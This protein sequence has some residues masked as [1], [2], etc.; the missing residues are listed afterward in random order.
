MKKVDEIYLLKQINEAKKE[1]SESD[2]LSDLEI[3]FKD[4]DFQFKNP[5]QLIES[6]LELYFFN[7]SFSG[8]RIDLKIREVS[9]KFNCIEFKGCKINCDIFIGESKFQRL[10]F[11]DVNITSRSFHISSSEISCLYILGSPENLNEIEN[12]FLNNARINNADIRLN[13]FKKLYIHTC[14]KLPCF[15]DK[16]KLLNLICKLGL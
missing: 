10:V 12:L 16:L 15:S 9:N 8:E 5:V 6:D 13:S 14:G 3:S 11:T 1:Y 7:C 4:I 2:D